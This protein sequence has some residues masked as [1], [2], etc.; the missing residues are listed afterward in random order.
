MNTLDNDSIINLEKYL[1]SDDASSGAIKKLRNELNNVSA[2][3]MIIE[4]ELQEL[5]EIARQQALDIHSLKLQARK[6]AHWPIPPNR[7]TL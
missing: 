5:R 1:Y 2:Y 4:E 3:V 7:L 6:Q